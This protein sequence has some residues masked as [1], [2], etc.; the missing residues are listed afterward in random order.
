LN[1]LVTPCSEN[2]FGVFERNPAVAISPLQSG[3]GLLTAGSL[4]TGREKNGYAKVR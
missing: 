4:L 1:E 2:V 3:N